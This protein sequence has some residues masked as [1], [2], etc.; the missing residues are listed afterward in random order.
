MLSTTIWLVAMSVVTDMTKIRYLGREEQTDVDGEGFGLS[1]GVTEILY[2]EEGSKQETGEILTHLPMR[3]TLRD[4][5]G[6]F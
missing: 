1:Y 3:G 5:S 2:M 6:T 4:V